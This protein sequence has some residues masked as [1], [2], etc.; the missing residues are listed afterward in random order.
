MKKQK[1]SQTLQVRITEE[2]FHKL[3]EYIRSNA[4]EFRNHSELLRT[5]ITEFIRRKKT[6]NSKNKLESKNGVQ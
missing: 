3:V 5:S 4:D 6:L 2:M 1:K